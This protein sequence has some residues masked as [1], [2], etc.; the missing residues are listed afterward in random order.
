MP[1]APPGS[2]PRQ[3][4]KS[5]I[6]A[7]QTADSA[8]KLRASEFL[9]FKNRSP[10]SYRPWAPPSVSPSS[11]Q[12]QMFWKLLFLVQ[13]PQAEGHNVGTGLL[14]L[15]RT[16]VIV[17]F[18]CVCITTPRVCV[19]TASCLYHCYP[20]H[21]GSFYIS[22]VVGNLYCLSSGCSQRQVLYKLLGFAR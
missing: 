22:L 5:N 4:S 20:F 16:S 2:C 18:S 1:P 10:V 21:C 14:S 12:S 11:V 17:T 6:S 19:L 13:D 9:P 15:R 3:T 7:F 8:L